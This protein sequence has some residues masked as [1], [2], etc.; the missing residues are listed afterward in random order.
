MCADKMKNISNRPSS[1]LLE[2]AN[3]QVSGYSNWRISIQSHTWRPP[4]DLFE[5][6]HRY[7][8]RMELAGMDQGEF[9]ISIEKN[10][11]SITGNRPDRF[12]KKAYHQM[13]VHFGEFRVD[14]EIP[15]PIQYNGIQA[16][17]KDGFLVLILPKENMNYIE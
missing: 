10:I 4:T 9:T 14:I 1:Y 7:I 13:E 15:G 2:E 11:L 8:I 6:E 5:M 17:Y 12:E 16:E 3:M